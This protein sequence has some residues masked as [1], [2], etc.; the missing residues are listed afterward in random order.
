MEQ[1]LGIAN[2][3]NSSVENHYGKPELQVDSPVRTLLKSNARNNKDSNI[4]KLEETLLLVSLKLEYQKSFQIQ[5]GETNKLT[6]QIDQL[7]EELSE[8]K[9][10][11]KEIKQSKI[12]QVAELDQVEVSLVLV[13]P[14]KKKKTNGKK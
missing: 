7:Q 4:T 13:K 6:E 12:D 14:G 11:F 10:N 9:V 5:Q 1:E 8:L 3:G 2:G